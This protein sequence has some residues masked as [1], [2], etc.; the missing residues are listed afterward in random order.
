MEDEL[1]SLFG[2]IDD[3]LRA[4][5]F[6]AVDREVASVD[7]EAT[8]LVLLLGWLSI[9]SAAKHKLAEREAL[10]ARVVA[11]VNRDEPTERAAALLRGLV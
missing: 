8:P 2:R 6:A 1:D 3:L 4:G 11:R 7:A 10:V 5:D 9:T